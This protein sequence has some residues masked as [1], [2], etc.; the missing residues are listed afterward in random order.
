MTELKP[1]AVNYTSTNH[2]FEALE[3]IKRHLCDVF[4]EGSS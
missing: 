2:H 4:R 1:V 3:T